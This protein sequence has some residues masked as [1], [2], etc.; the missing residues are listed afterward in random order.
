MSPVKSY[1]FVETPKGERGYVLEVDGDYAK[2][3]LSAEGVDPNADAM[4]WKGRNVP[5]IEYAPTLKIIRAYIDPLKRAMTTSAPAPATNP[6]M[7]AATSVNAPATPNA[8]TLQR[9]VPA[10]PKPGPRPEQPKMEPAPN[11]QTEQKPETPRSELGA[12]A[13]GEE[14]TPSDLRLE[15][16]LRMAALGIPL[17]R[18]KPHTKLPLDNGW[19]NRATTDAD[20]IRGWFSKDP[21]TNYACVAKANE[22]VF[23]ETDQPGVIERYEA[24]TGNKMPSTFTVQS[25]VGRF[26]H[27]FLQADA[28]RACG[29]ITQ[30][31]IPFGSLRQNNEYVVGPLSVHPDTGLPYTIVNDVP[32]VEIPDALVKWLD[33]QRASKSPK[34]KK[35]EAPGERTLIPHGQIHGAL[36]SEAGRMRYD[37]HT[38][39]S[40]EAALILWAHA[41]CVPPIDEAKV[42]QVAQ[43]MGNY[44]QGDPQLINGKLTGAAEEEIPIVDDPSE[45]D[46]RFQMQGDFFDTKVYEDI[47]RKSTPYPDPGEGDWISVLAKKIV[48]GTPMPLAFVR[49]PLK[50]IVLHALD[51]KLIHPANRN[52]MLRGNYFSIS[53]SENFKTK[54][55]EEMMR[56]VMNSTLLD[57]GA[58]NRL[59]IGPKHPESEVHFANLFKYKSEQVF[60]R[61]FTPEGN[62]KRDEQGKIKSGEAGHPNQFLYIKEGNQVANSSIYFAAVFSLLTNLYDQSE[63]ETQ[64][65]TTGD[66]NA[67]LVKTSAV[68]CFTLPDFGNTFG[69]KG[70]I[71][72]GGLNRWAIANPPRSRDYDEKDW[73][74]LSEEEIH[75]AAKNL[76]S[77]VYDLQ[78]GEPTVLIE[79][80]GATKIRLEVK[81]MLIDAGDI[82]KRLLEYFMREQVAQAVTVVDDWRLASSKEPNPTTAGDKRL[83]MTEKQ[84]HYA[85]E[86]VKAQL[87]ARAQCWPADAKSQ[88]EAM[89]HTIRKA[90]YTHHVSETK[91]KDACNYYRQ[92]SG[93]EFTFGTALKNVIQSRAI[94]VTALTRKGTNSYCPGSC[95]IHQALK[96]PRRDKK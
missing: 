4:H 12:P 40:I 54:G 64:S 88:I 13:T 95:G 30:K 46:P 80:P 90:V 82:G 74:R 28:S 5:S 35:D 29:N 56:F 87:E 55:L 47:A 44:K 78:I 83:V 48:H 9:L 73:E 91:L 24:E 93:G 32:I 65:F 81:K 3:Q 92:G 76:A 23:F 16:A 49:E 43:S 11:E 22:F 6:Q 59:V 38:V 67:K 51:G 61:S 63:A 36:V 20:T 7:G 75:E 77:A 52:L 21:N 18:L 27:Y 53:E 8:E 94:K 69:G 58:K 60:I 57:P 72:G 85:K 14:S 15:T 62:I 17:I 33:A 25:R 84:A 86:W 37:G 19:Q 96:P 89:E 79:E 71:G 2:V 45:D 66:F 68:M 70:N 31:E 34:A 41:N 10:T 39:E 26:H 1:D 42:K 50:A